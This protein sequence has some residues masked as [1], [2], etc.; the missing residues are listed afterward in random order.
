MA[1]RRAGACDLVL[2]YVPVFHQH[3]VLEPADVDDDPVGCLSDVGE[4]A[5]DHDPIALRHGSSV[6]VT[7]LRR[8][9]DDAEETVTASGHER[10]VLDAH[11]RSR[12]RSRLNGPSHLADRKAG[13][14]R[15]AAAPLAT[16]PDCRRAAPKS[17]LSPLGQNQG[18]FD[19]NTA[20]SDGVLD[21]GM[22]EQNLDRSYREERPFVDENG[23]LCYRASKLDCNACDL[24]RCCC[25]N[26]PARN[27]LRSLHE[28]ARDMVRRIAT[29]NAYVTSR[30]QRKKVEMLF[31]YLKRILR[32]D[33]VCG[34]NDEFLLEVK[35]K[36][37]ASS[38][39]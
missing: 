22:C 26:A 16:R 2:D 19:I 29:R 32:L 31:A 37:C 30:R 28:G 3:T 25:P 34:P 4:P 7:H 10:A 20:V 8:S 6:L 12:T 17:Y 11:P 21:L 13:I 38:P 24:E 23:M 15:A 1:A 9:R 18:V 5:M 39:S 14:G 35:A 33:R 36:T 27:I